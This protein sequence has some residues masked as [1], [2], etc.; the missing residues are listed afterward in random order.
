[1]FEALYLL[2]DVVEDGM[3]RGT[4]RGGVAAATA[5]RR[6]S[7]AAKTGVGLARGNGQNALS[8]SL[9]TRRG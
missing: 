1:V 2:V 8:T 9:W 3:V 7:I 4:G 5:S 6:E